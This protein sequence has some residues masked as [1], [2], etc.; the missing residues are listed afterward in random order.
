MSL[1]GGD[2]RIVGADEHGILLIHFGPDLIGVHITQEHQRL[3]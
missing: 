2:G 3:G 1:Q